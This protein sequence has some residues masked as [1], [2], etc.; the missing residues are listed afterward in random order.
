MLG[1]N[2]Y[3]VMFAGINARPPFNA[4]TLGIFGIVSAVRNRRLKLFQVHTLVSIF[5]REITLADI[6]HS[7]RRNC[8]LSTKENHPGA[9]TSTK[10]LSGHLQISSS[11]NFVLVD[12][13]SQQISTS[14]CLEI[15]ESNTIR[16][17]FQKRSYK[18][19]TDVTEITKNITSQ[20]CGKL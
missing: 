19:K 7:S 16:C 18:N 8:V 14:S 4:Y 12:W 17:G 3:R 11:H 13:H 6:H 5:M 2:N 9:Y 10:Y 15:T 1:I 20:E